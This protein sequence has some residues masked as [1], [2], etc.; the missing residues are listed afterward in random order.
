[1]T[2]SE[3]FTMNEGGLPLSSPVTLHPPMTDSELNVAADK[4]VTGPH[5]LAI[6]SGDL[7]VYYIKDLNQFLAKL[8][9]S[10]NTETHVFIYHRL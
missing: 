4:P 2:V 6:K 8:M 5:I 9:S 3:T 10:Q 7:L 1:M